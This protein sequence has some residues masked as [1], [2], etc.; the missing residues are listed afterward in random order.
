MWGMFPSR[1]VWYLLRLGVGGDELG[2]RP[3][4]PLVFFCGLI[5]ESHSGSSPAC[6]I[7]IDVCFWGGWPHLCLF[8]WLWLT[9]CLR[10][11]FH[12]GSWVRPSWKSVLSRMSLFCGW[13][14]LQALQSGML[15]K[16]DPIVQVWGLWIE[17]W[18]T[19]SAPSSSGHLPKFTLNDSFF[20]V[21]LGALGKW[22]FPVSILLRWKNDGG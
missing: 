12:C 9:L 21:K 11:D 14:S 4:I 17:W 13:V 2:F 22:H 20:S 6:Q 15:P 5:G 3:G 18:R 7:I 16:Q 1:K 19:P 10:R 8:F